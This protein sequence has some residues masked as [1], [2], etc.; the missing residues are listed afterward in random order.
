MYF[1]LNMNSGNRKTGNMPVSTS[2][3]NTCP[4][5][6]P[7]KVKGCYAAYSFLNIHWNKVSN[8]ERG[9]N[10]AGFIRQV[11]SIPK[12]SVWRH[13]VAG[14]NVANE[15]GELSKPHAMALIKANRGKQVISYTHHL[16][17]IGNN[18]F[19]LEQMNAQGFTVNLSANNVAQAIEYRRDYPRLPVV[20]LLPLDAPNVQ[21]AAG[22]KIVAC[23]AEKS[24]KVTCASC[25]LCADSKRDYII[26]FR[27]HGTGKKA[28]NKLAL[29][30]VA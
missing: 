27:A 25:K 3:K 10:F 19:I 26:G 6:C 15:R 14:D 24:D 22:H 16:P 7:L 29:V 12:G 11:A 30:E 21:T 9:T 5:T 1:H 18:K 4:E 17:S 2:S 23:P 28:V 13:N 20:T 8:G